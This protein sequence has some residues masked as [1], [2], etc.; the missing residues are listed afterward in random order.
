MKF[1]AVSLTPQTGFAAGGFVFLA[2]SIVA[3]LHSLP[4]VLPSALHWNVG[5]A[6]TACAGFATVSAVFFAL[7]QFAVRWQGDAS[8]FALDMAMQGVRQAYEVISA[9]N[10]P[11][12]VSWVNGARLLL[13]AE[14]VARNIAEPDH[15]DAWDL[16][17]EEWRIKFAAI[18]SSPAEYFFG[19]APD[20][21][22]DP[23]DIDY[24]D[25]RL[26]DMMLRASLQSTIKMTNRSGMGS[27]HTMLS[28]RALKV[29]YDFAKFPPEYQNSDFLNTVGDFT[30]EDIDQLDILS[31]WGLFA[32]LR[33]R[34]IF[35]ASFG[36]VH[37]LS[38]GDGDTR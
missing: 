6:A 31:R 27:D 26:E 20:S 1:G 28:L 32:Y 35:T 2:A 36:K 38:N 29:V 3:A 34:R 23:L 11:T 8:K 5:D 25:E 15:K 19:L 13:R 30:Q 37:R 17:K 10:P 21:Q 33:A 16:F 22:A 18:I 7:H 14:T 12:N 24:S 4:P 9:Q